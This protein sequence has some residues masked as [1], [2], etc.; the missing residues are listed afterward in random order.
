[1]FVG[2]GRNKSDHP[3]LSHTAGGL[4][5]VCFFEVLSIGVVLGLAWWAS[6]VTMD[7]LRLRWRGRIQPVLFGA[8]YSVGLRVAVGICAALVAM[9]LLAARVATVDSLEHLVQKNRPDVETVVDVSAMRDNPVYYWL[10]LTVVSFVVAGLR[11]ELW[12][13]SFLAGLEK[14]WPKQF[15][16]MGGKVGAAFIA[17]VI[18]GLG[19]LSM[20]WLAAVMAGLL[21]FGLGCIM[22]FHRSIWP[23]VMAHGFFDATSMALIPMALEMMKQLPQ[24]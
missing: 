17:S 20:G 2:L 7:D 24:H 1:M 19:H 18:F 23:A 4:L 14:L 12:R 9:V 6:R 22:V 21:G 15:G 8:A 3:A 13:A 16:S 10:T 5:E 11:E